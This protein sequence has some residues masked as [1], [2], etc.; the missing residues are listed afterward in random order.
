MKI[1]CLIATT[2]L[3]IAATTLPAKADKLDDI[4]ASGTL[5][6][7][8]TLDFPPMGSRDSANKPIGFDVDYCNDL[9]KALGVK[10]Q[11]V[12]TPFPARIPALVS[13]RA[14]VGVAAVS[15]TLERAKSIGFTIPYFVFTEAVLTKEGLGIKDYTDLKG[16]KTGSVSGTYEA[17]A[18]EKDVKAWGAGTTFRGY[19]NQADVFLALA[20][21]QID[22]TVVT[23]TVAASMVKEGKY[24]GLMMGGGRALRPRLRLPDRAAQ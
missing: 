13:G 19:Q 9:A 21:G 18:L 20:Q 10:A 6:C 23:S 11:I 5:R 22:A 1:T 15:D 8:V 2:A 17:L 4:I 12:E 24:K 7:A 3:T 16:K 14:D